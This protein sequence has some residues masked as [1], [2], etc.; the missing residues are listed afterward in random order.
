MTV[1]PR[2]RWRQRVYAARGFVPVGLPGRLILGSLLRP[3]A[4][5]AALP[6]LAR[7]TSRRT[8]AQTPNIGGSAST[9]IRPHTKWVSTGAR[10]PPLARRSNAHTVPRMI[11]ANPS[12]G[13]PLASCST[14]TNGRNHHRVIAA[15]RRIKRAAEEDLLGNAVDHGDRDD[16]PKASVLGEQQHP[17]DQ[18]RDGRYLPGDQP[19][20]HE[21]TAK[22]QSDGRSRDDRPLVAAA[23]ADATQMQWARKEPADDPY[24]RQAGQPVEARLPRMTP[25]RKPEHRGADHQRDRDDDAPAS[26]R[27]RAVHYGAQR[28]W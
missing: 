10:T 7:E 6:A 17:G 16:Q 11:A 15:Q 18:G 13:L 27:R 23:P 2:R 9:M 24:R 20:Q 26:A 21:H 5:L 19:A 25:Q 3:L 28:H 22:Q 1:T 8:V 14:R 12:I 4:Y